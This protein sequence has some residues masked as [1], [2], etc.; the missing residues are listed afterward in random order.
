MKNIKR[1]LASFLTVLMLQSVVVTS[2]T[3][4]SAT[5]VESVDVNASSSVTESDTTASS[6]TLDA[7]DVTMYVGAT[8]KL[9]ATFSPEGS[10]STIK[11]SSSNLAVVYVD[12]N[13]NLSALKEG[14]A[15]IT[16]KIS[17]GKTATCN[18]A[19]TPAP[20][21]VTLDKTEITIISGDTYE[22]KP[23]VFPAD[24]YTGY[25]WTT[26][27]SNIATVSEEGVV[28]GKKAGKVSV[29]VTTD[30]GKSTV[31]TV[32]VINI[33]SA[34][35]LN[36]TSLTLRPNEAF[37]LIRS[38]SPSNAVATVSWSSNNTSVATVDQ[39]G[40]VTAKAIGEAII[41]VETDNGKKAQCVV[42]VKPYPTT[43]DL[44]KSNINLVIG[45]QEKIIP[46]LTPTNAYTTYT[47]TTD[48]SKI[49]TV[50]STGVI[51]GRGVGTATITAI[52][53]NGLSKSVSV[54]VSAEPTSITINEAKN[55]NYV[56]L[57]IGETQQLTTTVAPANVLTS[58]TWTSGNPEVATVDSNGLVKAVSIG[59]TIV[60]V[61]TSNGKKAQCLVLVGETPT[62]ITLNVHEITINSE[63]KYEMVPTIQPT[64]SIVKELT[65]VS[66]NTKVVGL[67]LTNS[68]TC[69][70][71]GK[72]PGTATLTVTTDNNL[73]DVCVITV[74]NE[75]RSIKITKTS[76][77]K[78]NT[79][80][81]VIITKTISPSNAVSTYTWTS[82]DES[83]AT[84]DQN[85]KVSGLAPGKATIT[86]KAANG[87]YA[88]CLVEVCP[89]PSSVSLSDEHISL[90]TNEYYTLGYELNPSNAL[91]TLTWSTSNSNVAK[92]SNGKVTGV[93]SGTATITIKTSNGKTASCT[94]DVL[95]VPTAIS[96]SGKNWL[97]VGEKVEM[98]YTIT[99][100]LVETK[101]TWTSSNTEVA[102]VDA[103]GTI[104][105]L[106]YGKTTIRVETDNGKYATKTINVYNMP[107]SM[108][109][110]QSYMSMAVGQTFTFEPILKPD[111]SYVI[112]NW[113]ISDDTIATLTKS[114][115]ITAKKI[116]T[117]VVT[118]TNDLGQ[119][120]TC[121]ITVYPAPESI[122]LNQT[123]VI[124]TVKNGYI[125]KPTI[126]PSNALTSYTWESSNPEVATVS[127]TGYIKTLKE[128]KT[129]ITVKT[130][131]NKTASCE[132]IVSDSPVVVNLDYENIVLDKNATKQLNATCL[133]TAVQTKY[134]WTS[135]NTSVAK[136]SST[137]LVTGVGNGIA[138]ITVKASNGVTASCRVTVTSN[139]PTS[140]SLNAS[141]INV[142]VGNK[143][144]VVAKITP[145][146]A[147]T[148]YTWKSDNT[149][150]ATVNSSGNITGV[151]SGTANIT[152]TTAN[153]K[154]AS[155][156]VNV[157][158]QPT[159]IK[160]SKEELTLEVGAKYRVA[161]TLEPAEAYTTYT[162]KSSNTAIATV[163][164]IGNITAVKEGVAT[165]TVTTAN[166]LTATA[167]V[168]V[169]TPVTSIKFSSS[170]VSVQPGATT[171]VSPVITPSSGSTHYTWTSSNTAVATVS[172]TGKVTGVSQGTAIITVTTDRGKKASYTIVVAKL[173]TAVTLPKTTYKLSV[174][175]RFRLSPTI[176][177]ADAY[178]YL[179]WTS[180]NT[181][182]A[183]VSDTGNILAVSAG[184]AKITGTTVNGLKVTCT[185]T[186]S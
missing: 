68:G 105:G 135:S 137:G 48:N 98:P 51:T 59:L 99:P 112:Y 85:G 17:N 115:V 108:T 182:V 146:T 71:V 114:G 7:F 133:P 18:I 76:P 121:D 139:G 46:T 144:R 38:F 104:T 21:Y 178:N 111:N 53:D 65:W 134:T 61:E 67:E 153:N 149:A 82:S 96:L 29:A 55:N 152:V 13:G 87:V 16:A 142:Q 103:D 86:I 57:R 128:G 79:G 63:D 127:D 70:I 91:T 14:N 74:T 168:I 177:P 43:L 22:L 171:L 160:L 73:T 172:S 125:L 37:T 94:V 119:V 66:S 52:T 148:T 183:T 147:T 83:V 145:E 88:S 26:T 56:G 12:D 131:N 49:A 97:R 80:S 45:V 151:K 161:P 124:Q 156:K 155:V 164:S 81:S 162:W 159:S 47:W 34:V 174:G 24:A 31:C 166:G 50:S 39:N 89:I 28:T 72:S 69:K 100:A 150:V 181:A 154:T 132:V 118:L 163:N 44:S 176:T 110:E 107:K 173:P 185:V 78:I 9:N 58:Y 84:V 32:N 77:I 141:A 169:G 36:K 15:T 136:V 109:F 3:S 27:D 175:A 106:K 5:D 33:P 92:V 158:V 117:T 126:T 157:Y 35:S 4:V 165:I 30:N 186:V 60:T 2:V 143:Y 116:G 95:G 8:K 122:K 62:G 140:V 20:E 40:K 138:D 170:S 102:T 130:T 123:T 93:G 25:S 167:N 23:S 11:W 54:T 64:T 19:V 113:S 180:N 120:A 129:T 179:T 10:T 75:V 1:A 41:I 101:L 90:K 184:T 42:S 6:I